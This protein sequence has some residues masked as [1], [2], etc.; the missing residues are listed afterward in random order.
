MKWSKLSA[1]GWVF[2][3]AVLLAGALAA[4]EPAKPAADPAKPVAKEGAEKKKKEAKP[5]RGRL[6]NYYGQVVDDVQRGKIYDI[7]AKYEGQLAAL[8]KQIADLEKELHAEVEGVLNAE[9]L[10]KV[11]Q[12]AEEARNQRES[13]KPEQKPEPKPEPN[14]ESTN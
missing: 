5:P 11:K 4:Q 2:A 10:A 14:K 3:L 13:S 12:L 7:Q 9:Q 1:Q 6:P 8:R